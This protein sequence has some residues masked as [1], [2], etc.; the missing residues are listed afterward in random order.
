MN[1][2]QELK[3]FYNPKVLNLDKLPK[4]SI[5]TIILMPK[6]WRKFSKVKIW[7]RRK[8]V[9]GSQLNKVEISTVMF[10]FE[11]RLVNSIIKN[12]D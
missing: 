6:K 1:Q 9:N 5:G 2:R 12:P 7:I 8:S 3:P 10:V 11:V 4:T